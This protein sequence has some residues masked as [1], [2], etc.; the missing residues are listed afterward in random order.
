MI[1]GRARAGLVIGLIVI[2]SALA[3]AAAERM[4]HQRGGGRRGGPG[5]GG[6]GGRGVMSREADQKRRTEMLDR[7]TKELSLTPAQRA[8]IDSVMQRTDSSLRAIRT[9]MQP[10]IQ[11][12][13][14]RSRVEMDARLDSA[15]RVKFDSEMA[16][17][18]R[19]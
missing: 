16:R 2:C 14:E 13:F 1:G 11:K 9:Q 15:Q 7:M 10:E 6:P 19:P 3:G 12:V 18:R 4:M 5:G 8:G 17:R